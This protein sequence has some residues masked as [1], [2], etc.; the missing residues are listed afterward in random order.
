M[1]QRIEAMAQAVETVRGPLDAFYGLL[2]YEQKAKFNEANQPPAQEKNGRPQ[3][4]AQSCTAANAAT[5]WPEARIEA[6][7]RPSEE[8]QAKFK[9]LQNAAAQA[10]EQLAASCPSEMPTTRRPV[11]RTYQNG[12]MSC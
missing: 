6:A 11:L 1:E 4:I 12:S 3:A 10:A 5:Q 9:A 2:T 7:P 8:Q